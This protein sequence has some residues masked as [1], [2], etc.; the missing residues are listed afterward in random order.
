MSAVNFGLIMK[1]RHAL[2]AVRGQHRHDSPSSARASSANARK[3]AEIFPPRS[4]N[5]GRGPHLSG[6]AVSPFCAKCEFLWPAAGVQDKKVPFFEFQRAKR[7][8]ALNIVWCNSSGQPCI[9]A[10]AVWP[11]GFFAA[12]NFFQ[13]RSRLAPWR[14]T[15]PGVLSACRRSLGCGKISNF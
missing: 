10:P 14:N 2:W 5:R 1:P 13:T 11:R 12:R 4:K 9:G 3:Q 15:M 6:L 8:S 7:V